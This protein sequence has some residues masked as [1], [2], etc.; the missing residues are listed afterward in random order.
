MQSITVDQFI[1]GLCAI[2]EEEFSVGTVHEYLKGN[3]VDERSLQ[4][5]LFFSKHRYTRNLIFKNRLFEL[6]ALCWDVGQSSQ[7]HNHQDQ[8]CWMAMPLGRLRVQNFRVFEQNG[9]TNYCRIEPT[10]AFDIHAL[11]P[12]E[13]DPADPVH[14]VLNLP[15]F[16]L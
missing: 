9:R 6:L 12:A 16:N 2:P 10:D 7:I 14:Q 8:N 3:P 13:V 5:Y 1:A 4:P 11:M 15:E